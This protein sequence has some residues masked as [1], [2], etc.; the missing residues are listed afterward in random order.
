MSLYY[1]ERYTVLA[2]VFFVCGAVSLLFSFADSLRD[3]PYS[4][5]LFLVAGAAAAGYVLKHRKDQTYAAGTT[6]FP[7]VDERDVLVILKTSWIMQEVA[8]IAL[9]F[10]ALNA[11]PILGLLTGDIPS[12]VVSAVQVLLMG[13]LV[14]LALVY[15]IAHSWFER[16]V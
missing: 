10:A 4:A 6:L 7:K 1:F 3:F 2:A 13:L 16:K 11:G 12:S 9:L 14:V 15:L 8:V 5:V